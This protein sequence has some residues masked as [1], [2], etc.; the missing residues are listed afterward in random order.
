MLFKLGK[1]APKID[2]KTLRLS[3]YV[4]Y[5][6]LPPPPESCDW[7]C[8]IPS[9]PMLKNDV[10]CIC[11]IAG[12]GHMYQ[13]WTTYTK[14]AP[15]IP[16]DKEVIKAYSKVSGYDPQTGENDN[17][18][19]LL[20]VLKY[21]RNS[22][23]GGHKIIG[24]IALSPYRTQIKTGLWLFGGLD[25]GIALPKYIEPTMSTGDDWDVPSASVK[26]EDAQPGSLGG[27]CVNIIAYNEKG[28]TCAT[29]GRTQFMTWGFVSA[30]VDEMYAVYSKDW[31]KQNKAPNGFDNKQLLK[32]L[33]NI[34]N[35]NES[36]NVI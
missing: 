17:G 8:K 32:D 20:D 6:V 5:A 7:G 34:T 29:W 3:Y 28:L 14:P 35:V 22:G 10:L 25:I 30:Y 19:Y 31:F 26:P 4:D 13:L 16:S 27:H 12:P 18:C 9:W 24:F 21:W 2:K 36:N 11:A 33:D 23:I 15:H 1:L